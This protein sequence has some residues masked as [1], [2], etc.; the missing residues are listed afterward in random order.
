MHP[1]FPGMDPYLEAAG[2]WPGFHEAF[3]SYARETIQP[4][5]PASYYAELRTREEIGIAGSRPGRVLYPDLAVLDKGDRDERR[6]G[7]IR[8]AAGATLTAPEHLRI[9]EDEPLRIGFLEIRDAA[10]DHVLATLIE[11][12]SPSNK[13]AGSDRETFERKQREVL[14]SPTSWVQID[15][16]RSGDRVACHPSVEVHC[17]RKGYDYLVTVS[18]PAGRAPRL[19][20]ELYGFTVRDPLPVVAIPLIEPDPDVALDL[21]VVFRRAYETGPYRKILEYREPPDLRLNPGDEA[22]ARDLVEQVLGPG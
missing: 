7:S 19:G 21:G 8:S 2:A 5:L 4:L 17:R 12:L 20:L 6:R 11:L 3:L 14:S 9:I 15:L 18:R 16:L 22:W 10:R 1:I 13:V